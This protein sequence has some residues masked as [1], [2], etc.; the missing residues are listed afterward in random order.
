MTKAGARGG[1]PPAREG[2]PEK[3]RLDEDEDGGMQDGGM[4]EAWVERETRSG[5]KCSGAGR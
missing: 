2:V 4:Q 5:G 1:S 3:R